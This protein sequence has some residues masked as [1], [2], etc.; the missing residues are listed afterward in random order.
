MSVIVVRDPHASWYTAAPG[1]EN[2]N[3]AAEAYRAAI[4]HLK[5]ELDI[6]LDDSV[7]HKF[8]ASIKDVFS[9]VE[10]AKK[11]YEDKGKQDKH[12]EMRQSL[13]RLSG[14]IMYYGKVMDTLAQH[15]P[16][17][18]ALVW[19]AMKFVLTA[20]I[21][22]GDVLPRMDLSAELYQTQYMEAALSRLFT[23]II[24][25]LRLC[26]RWYKKSPLGR[27]CSAIKTPFELGYQ[28]LVNHIQECSKAVDDLAS[29]G[30]RAEIRD[31]H[32][33]AMLQHA[34]IREL[35]AKLAGVME[36]Q[37]KF[38]AHITQL[39]Q[40][41]TSHKSITERIGVDV[42]SISK[43]VYRLEFSRV[44]QF[45]EP[46]VL[47]E[48]ALLKVRSLVHRDTTPSLPSA[49]EQRVRKTILNWAFGKRSSLLVVQVGIRAQKQ[50][51]ELATNVI[52]SMKLGSQHVFWN[53]PSGRTSSDAQTIEE[54][55]RGIIFQVLQHSGDLFNSCAEQLN[56]SKIHATHTEREWV[57]LVC[58]LFSK[59]PT[60]FVIIETEALQKT[61]RHDPDWSK[62]LCQYLEM[63]ADRSSEAGCELKILL[64]LYGNSHRG[65]A[66]ASNSKNVR[67]AT[68]QP[69]NPVPPHLRHVARRSGLVAKEW[70]MQRPKGRI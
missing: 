49:N 21:A 63:I 30:A 55:F 50:A 7:P 35:D 66:A 13:E 15:H 65:G 23:Y 11:D 45:F 2:R 40:V 20:L 60:A 69:P 54:L 59:L 57:D 48:T 51:K 14:R 61:Y 62:R 17:Y 68:L 29:A 24:L 34:Q 4:E 42:C 39:L 53:L 27:I 8:Q 25:F 70:K 6:S 36:G 38:A 33:L 64:V 31:V 22:I 26:V 9:V 5:N 12:A 3:I 32:T 16:E 58:L 41:A 44:M 43:T 46:K 10:N 18:V 28:D 47:P 56:L 1:Q 19:G 52:Q 37:K 67:V